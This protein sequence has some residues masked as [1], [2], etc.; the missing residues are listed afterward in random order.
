MSLEGVDECLVPEQ[1][2]LHPDRNLMM[3]KSVAYNQG[4]NK[5]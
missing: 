1:A 5:R 2:G 3:R 4:F